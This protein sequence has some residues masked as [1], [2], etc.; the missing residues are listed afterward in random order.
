MGVENP[1]VAHMQDMTGGFSFF[2]LYGQLIHTV[3]YTA[4]E[5]LGVSCPNRSREEIDRLIRRELKK[6]VVVVGACIESDAHTVGIDAIINLKGYNGRKGL[7]SY[8]EIAACNLGAQ[9]PCEELVKK[10]VELDAQV[11]LVSQVVTQKDIHLQNLTRLIDIIEA[12]GLRERFLLIVGGPRISHDL[13]KELGYDAGFGA[14]T[15]AG[16]VASFMVEELIR[17]KETGQ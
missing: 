7:E 17:R 4:V 13:A 1:Q 11:I 6:K 15:Y 12:E 10:A 5:V 14:G 9:V 3:D 16:Q 2:V 8:R